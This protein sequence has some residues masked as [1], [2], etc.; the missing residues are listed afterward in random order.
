MALYEAAKGGLVLAAGFSL[1]ALL[2][3]H[4]QRFAGQLVGHLHLNPAKRYPNIFGTVFSGVPDTRLRLLA[5]LAALYTVMR[6][7]EAFGLWFGKPWAEWF[8][9][10]SSGVYLPVEL[11][12]LAKGF[13]WLKIGFVFINLAM[14]LYLGAALRKGREG[15]L[16]AGNGEAGS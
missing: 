15:N 4:V 1:F 11:Y 14:V 13:S 3:H 9:L 8:A 2:H 16:P 7:V 12:E 6:F 5:L 10:S